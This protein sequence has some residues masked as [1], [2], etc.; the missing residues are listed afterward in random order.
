MMKNQIKIFS[1]VCIIVVLIFLYYIYETRITSISIRGDQYKVIAGYKNKQEAAQ[2]IAQLNDSMISFLRYL[3]E[4]YRTH[5]TADVRNIIN[6]IL[7]NYNP[8]S[9]VENDPRFST[10]TAY[11]L[12]KG[13]K[14]VLCVRNKQPP[15]DIVDFNTLMFVVLHEV[16]GHIGNYN[17]WQHTQR[18]W[19]IFK[20][21]LHE[22]VNFG[23]YAPIDYSVK[24]VVYCGLKI[25]YQP[26]FDEKLPKLWL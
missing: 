21:I 20:F 26:L 24:P 13:R 18:F 8:E 9:I 12:D 7:I 3:R 16:G 6:S 25:D 22:A 15:Y 5:P 19:T 10:N 2:T 23:I 11:T 4:K 14:I 1:A 17:G